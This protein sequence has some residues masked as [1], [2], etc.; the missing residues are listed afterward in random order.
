MA[1]SKTYLKSLVNRLCSLPGQ[2]G[3]SDLYETPGEA[4]Q[5][6]RNELGRALE[7]HAV[8]DQ[9]GDRI[10][11]A[12]MRGTF[13]PVPA[14]IAAM[15]SEIPSQQVL[16]EGCDICAGQPWVSVERIQWEFPKAEGAMRGKQYIASGSKRCECAKGRWFQQKDCEN[17]AKRAAGLPV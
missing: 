1:V 10:V 7:R 12:L 3:Q 8:S 5:A 14:E 4:K 15:A 2:K 16:P 11:E 17:E 9:H 13:R 6:I